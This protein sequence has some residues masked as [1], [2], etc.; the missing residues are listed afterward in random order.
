M[1]ILGIVFL[2]CMGIV[3]SSLLSVVGIKGMLNIFICVVVAFVAGN[4]GWLDF[5]IFT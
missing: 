4:R 1:N 2:F 5:L 3:L